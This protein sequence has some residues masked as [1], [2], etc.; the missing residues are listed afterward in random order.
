[1]KG[2]KNLFGKVGRGLLEGLNLSGIDQKFSRDHLQIL[3]SLREHIR[4]TKS[5]D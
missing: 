1:M 5:S 2:V 3:D 4:K